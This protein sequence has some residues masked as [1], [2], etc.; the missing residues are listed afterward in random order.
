MDDDQS[1]YFQILIFPILIAALAAAWFVVGPG[2]HSVVAIGST[3]GERLSAFAD[4]YQLKLE[5]SAKLIAP[6]ITIASGSYAIVKAYKFAESRLQYRLQDFLDREEKRL[7]D[8]REQLRLIVERPAAGRP[9][10]TPMFLVPAMKRV[11]RELGWGSYFLP[12]QLPYVDFQIGQSID[13]L[14]KQVKLSSERQDHLVS[15]LATAH[16]LK[17]ALLAADA[18]KNHHSGQ[19]DRAGLSAALNHFREALKADANDVEALEYASQMHVLLGDDLAAEAQ[20]NH[21]LSLVPPHGKSLS[22][23]RALRYKAGIASRDG[24][25]RVAASILEDALQ[26][27]PV[28]NGANR[29]E[30]AEMYYAL[31]SCQTDGRRPGPANES[32]RTADDIMVEVLEDEARTSQRSNWFH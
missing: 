30:E 8:A 10:R 18:S 24:T 6:V 12:P 16:L 7:K 26:A 28:Q 29:R 19:P 1:S 27:L 9:F 3:I 23:A 11:V 5:G 31:S 15:Q 13:Q 21:L 22:R 25:P 4:W 14:E 20:L 32:K 2:S 17:G